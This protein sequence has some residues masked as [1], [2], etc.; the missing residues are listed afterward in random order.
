MLSRN[1]GWETYSLESG[2]GGRL[3]LLGALGGNY[4]N[5]RISNRSFILRKKNSQNLLLP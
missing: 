5:T 1:I 4:S 2:L 3:G